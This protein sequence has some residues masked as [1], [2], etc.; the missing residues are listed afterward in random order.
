MDRD[1]IRRLIPHAG[2]MCL[3]DRVL[4]WDEAGIECASVSHRDP[5]NPLRRAG[6]LPAVC[7]IEYA[8]Q[9]MA[10]HGA[11]R[12]SAPQPAGYLS[13]LRGVSV[14]AARLDDVEGPLAV[15]AA[16]LASESRGFIYR[17]DVHGAGRLLLSGQAAIIL[18][19]A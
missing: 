19:A 18:A 13:S 5:G 8:L 7:G 14:A 3:L 17:F 2:R 4:R 10:A 12:A 1:A 9:A 15:G 16:V 6:M 11:L